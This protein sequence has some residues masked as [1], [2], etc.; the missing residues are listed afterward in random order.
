MSISNVDVTVMC[1]RFGTKYSVEYVKKLR[2][3]VARHLT[4]P[5][6]FAC[7]TDDPTPIDG[8]RL[9][10][11]PMFEY[12]Q[13]WWHKVHMFDP[14]I[15]TA[16]VILYF[17]LDVVICN[18]IDH[19]VQI[20][21]TQLYG[22]RDFN[23]KFM[24]NIQYLNSSV[25]CWAAGEHSELYTKFKTDTRNALML[26]GDQDWIWAQAKKKIQFWP[27]PWIQSYKWE[28][29]SKKELLSRT[30]ESGFKFISDVV[31][32]PDCCVAVFHGDPNPEVVSD[33]FVVAN[34][35]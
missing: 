1:V 12:R 25:L 2:N 8:V 35:K 6:E 9:I 17:D 21:P 31:P 20:N 28:I 22:I 5:Y 27:D 18:S 19:L 30:G 34:W 10:V 23:R 15:T 4:V 13:L 29:R 33:P 14:T 11:Q 3:M 32:S 26:R 16:P 7:I 24:H